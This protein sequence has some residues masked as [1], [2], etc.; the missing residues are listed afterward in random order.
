MAHPVELEIGRV[1]RAHGLRG[2]VL[3]T[4]VTNRLER[5]APGS[6]LGTERGPLEVVSSR[7]H[8]GRHLVRFAGITD[9]SA[10]EAL[11]GLV[12][13]AAPL[14]DPDELWVHELIGATVVDVGGETHGEV[15]AVVANPASDLLELDDGTL[16]PLCFVVDSDPGRTVVVDVPPG[17][18]GAQTP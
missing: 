11:T 10:A 13:T 4:L 8:K 17:L 18:F 2:E 7:P 6:V 15:V 16:V 9:R 5:L 3:V 12:L 14:D 1:G